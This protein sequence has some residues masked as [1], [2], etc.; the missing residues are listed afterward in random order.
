MRRTT[1]LRQMIQG[2]GLTLM[3]FTYDSFTARIAEVS[4]FPA[5]YVSGFGSAMGKG[6]PDIGLITETEMVQNG[7]NIARVTSIPILMD[8]DTGYGNAINVWRTVRDYEAAGIAGCHIEDQVFPKKC[9]F[10]EGKQVIPMDEAV[11]KVRAALDARTDPDF[12]IVARCDAL[13]INGWED[14]LRR[15]RAYRD[16]GADMVFVDGVGTLEDLHTYATELADIPRLFNGDLAPAS[17]IER[18]G[19]KIQ[20]HRGP[21]FAVYKAV[22]EAM[23]ELLETGRLDAARYDGSTGARQAIANTL[24]LPLFYE[25]EK[26]YAAG[27]AP[28]S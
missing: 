21:M 4:G 19:F 24:G 15:C 3:P 7:W 18:L 5:V 14:T 16:A 27:K 2:D 9:G 25:M 1:K 28:A 20:I 22:H 12:V 17:E 26:R 6:Y 8:A 13:A 10:F 11:Q 23:K